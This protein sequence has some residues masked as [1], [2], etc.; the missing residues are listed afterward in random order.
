MPGYVI[1]MN[2]K[3]HLKALHRQVQHLGALAVGESDGARPR[4]RQG[5]G[6]E[7]RVLSP[8]VASS[9]CSLLVETLISTLAVYTFSFQ[10]CPDQLWYD[11]LEDQ[12]FALAAQS[13]ASPFAAHVHAQHTLIQAYRQIE[14]NAEASMPWCGKASLGR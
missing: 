9:R 1:P 3:K 11:C 7:P 13:S 4:A 8:R 12:C 14:V 10:M 5:P 2:R 6:W